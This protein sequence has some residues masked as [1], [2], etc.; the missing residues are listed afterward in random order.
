MLGLDSDENL[1]NV[2]N[3]ILKHLQTE[4]TRISSNKEKFELDLKQ[5]NETS[6]KKLIKS[7]YQE[8][9]N[10]I[11]SKYKNI[12]IDLDSSEVSIGDEEKKKK[13]LKKGK[14]Y[15]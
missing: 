7:I 1:A 11:S 15:N 13:N 5:V 4:I 9:Y 14:Y 3:F 10:L 2:I 8:S 6:T 12:T